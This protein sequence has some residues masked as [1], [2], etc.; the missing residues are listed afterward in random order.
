MKRLFSILLLIPLAAFAGG[1]IV[2]E[3]AWVREAPPGASMMAAY[4]VIRNPGDNAVELVG[5]D[6]PDFAHVRMHKSETVDGMARMIHRDSL[7][8]PAHSS[9]ALKPGGFHLMMPAPT[10]RLVQG[11]KVELLLHFAD[12][13]CVRATAVV[14]KKP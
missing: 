7:T 14:R 5:V 2:V 13:R 4:L 8:I 9:V 3:N 6:S 11:D 1:A 12:E 10:T